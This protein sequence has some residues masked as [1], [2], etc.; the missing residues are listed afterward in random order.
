MWKSVLVVGMTLTAVLIAAN[1]SAQAYKW[2][3]STGNIIYSQTPPPMGTPYE[4]VDDASI[5]SSNYG[6]S[7]TKDLQ[8]NLNSSQEVREKKKVEQQQLAESNQIKQENCAQ[9]KTNLTSLT[10]R[11]Q[12]TIKEGD[13]Y[14]KLTE[15]ERQE[16]I[17]S[18]NQNIEEFCN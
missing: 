8:K 12:V 13:L 15:E 18:A 14:R 4:L 6:V 11:G 3:S 17:T 16:R 7:R 5:A 9:A 1:A 10:S 2:T